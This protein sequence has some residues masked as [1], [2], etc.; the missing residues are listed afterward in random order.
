M[1]KKYRKKAEKF[2]V[3]VQLDL[4]TE[5]FEYEKWGSKQKCKK[6]DWLVKNG[7]E[8][9]TIDQ[10]VFKK[11]YKE[12]SDGKFVKIIP[13]WAEEA[14]NVGYILTKEGKSYYQVGDYLVFNDEQKN[15]GYC[16]SR[17]EF[18]SLYELIE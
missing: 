17:Y 14:L 3:A 2:I 7:T 11:S 13:V 9:Y 12:V 4:D 18:N 16:I 15:D 6:G 10:E 5:G 1:L 8:I